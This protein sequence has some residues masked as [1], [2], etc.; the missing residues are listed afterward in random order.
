[1][2]RWLFILLLPLNHIAQTITFDD[3]QYCTMHT[4]EEDTVY[5]AENHFRFFKKNSSAAALSIYYIRTEKDSVLIELV[6]N[7]IEVWFVAA[8]LKNE[9]NV[10]AIKQQAIKQGYLFDQKAN[11]SVHGERYRKDKTYI[12]FKKEIYGVMGR[13]FEVDYND[14]SSL[15]SH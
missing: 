6:T 12:S 3:L 9:K 4:F 5:L 11:V 7:N 15:R 10:L 13:H 1:M 8:Q 2:L 14:Q